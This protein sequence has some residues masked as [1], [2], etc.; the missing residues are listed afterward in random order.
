[1]HC[2][3]AS[4]G[5]PSGVG[6][7]LPETVAGLDAEANEDDD[8]DEGFAA[9]VAGAIASWFVDDDLCWS[10]N[11]TRPKLA[12]ATNPRISGVNQGMR[13]LPEQWLS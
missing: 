8:A 4:A 13:L 10:K 1:V 6:G 3:E 11:E 7:G 2:V 5:N 9:M 12:T